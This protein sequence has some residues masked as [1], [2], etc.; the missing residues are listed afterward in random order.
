MIREAN[1]KDIAAINQLGGLL[2]KN[3]SNLYDFNK[4]LDEDHSKVYVVEVD[5][6]IIGFLHT[7]ILYE[8]IDIEN[9]V[10]NPKYQKNG[11]ATL[12]M[13]YML[14]EVDENIEFITLE[15][16]VDNNAALTLYENFGFEIINKRVGYYE[17][18]DAYLMGKK[19]R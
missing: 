3:F 7:T 15:V 5:T 9:I 16:R 10:I 12:L 4:I 18:K 13:D 1:I 8:N 6:E 19:V 2:K 14:S 11:Y 17:G